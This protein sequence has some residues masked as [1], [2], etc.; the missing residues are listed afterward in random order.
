MRKKKTP[1]ES[2]AH[3]MFYKN[4]TPNKHNTIQ[5][6]DSAQSPSFRGISQQGQRSAGMATSLEYKVIYCHRCQAVSSSQIQS[7]FV[8]TCRCV[9][10]ELKISEMQLRRLASSRKRLQL[11]VTNSMTSVCHPEILGRKA[12]L[13]SVYGAYGERYSLSHT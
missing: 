3:F 4:S 7:S 9:H 2:A 1:F 8:L 12:S 13:A 10:T 6:N 11:A 5:Y